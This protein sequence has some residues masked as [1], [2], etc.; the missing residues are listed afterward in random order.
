MTTSKRA[1]ELA[2]AYH[3]KTVIVSDKKTGEKHVLGLIQLI[4]GVPLIGVYLKNG[5]PKNWAS[6]P[7]VFINDGKTGQGKIVDGELLV[8]TTAGHYIVSPWTSVGA[9]PEDTIFEE[10]VYCNIPL[11]VSSAVV[12]TFTA[13]SEVSYTV[14]ELSIKE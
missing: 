2:K 9:T 3:G 7:V 13:G 5:I 4:P 11:K 8:V 12:A 10:R 6:T 14:D 1:F